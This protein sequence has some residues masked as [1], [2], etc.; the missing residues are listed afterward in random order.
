MAFV[1]DLQQEFE[2]ESRSIYERIQQT[3]N[4]PNR[5]QLGSLSFGLRSEEVG[6]QVADL[7]AYE[8]FSHV[9]NTVYTVR[10][11]D[12]QVPG[13]ARQGPPLLRRVLRPRGP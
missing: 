9:R 13:E 7:L 12:P 6:L 1:C 8:T 10:G 3:E 11:G 2:A 5:R 4:W